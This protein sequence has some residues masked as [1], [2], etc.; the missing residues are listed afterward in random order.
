MLKEE[1]LHRQMKDR[2]NEE[3]EEEAAMAGASDFFSVLFSLCFLSFFLLQSEEEG[4]WG[5]NM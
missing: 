1:R 2:H 3:E 4:E 5:L